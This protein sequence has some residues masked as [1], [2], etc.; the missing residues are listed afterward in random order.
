[1]RVSYCQII[2]TYSHVTYSYVD[3]LRAHLLLR[4]KRTTTRRAIGAISSIY[5]AFPF[6]RCPLEQLM[7][8]SAPL[9]GEISGN[10]VPQR[11]QYSPPLTNIQFKRDFFSYRIRIFCSIVAG[12]T[13]TRS[14]PESTTMLTKNQQQAGRSETIRARSRSTLEAC[15]AL[16]Y[17]HHG[18]HLSGRMRACD[19]FISHMLR[20]FD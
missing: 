20:I 9:K 14:T 17:C 6:F 2:R 15:I 5:G 3:V 10:V 1:M 18:G 16:D 7:M 4:K 8:A 11:L 12:Y 19:I 13:S